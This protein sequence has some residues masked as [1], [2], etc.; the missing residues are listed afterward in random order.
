MYFLE[1]A[2]TVL[3]GLFIFLYPNKAYDY[4]K[5]PNAIQQA[6]APE[7][8][9]MLLQFCGPMFV[10]IGAGL[11]YA[12]PDRK[13]AAAYRRVAALV[14]LISEVLFV[15]WVLYKAAGDGGGFDRSRLA[16][17]GLSVVPFVAFRGYALF[18]NPGLL[19]SESLG[20]KRN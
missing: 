13:D 9:L 1:G 18:G 20:K 7:T 8:T 16:Q 2:S 3:S 4:L 5:S 10:A 6:L 12:M 17:F 15:P 11:L 14:P 19:E